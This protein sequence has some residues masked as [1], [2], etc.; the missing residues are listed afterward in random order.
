MPE[1]AIDEESEESEEETIATK[2]NGR[3]E[4]EI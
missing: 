3:D 2:Q 1:A 4:T